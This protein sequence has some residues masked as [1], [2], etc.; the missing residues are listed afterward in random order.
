M[1]TNDWCTTKTAKRNLTRPPG[2]M[3]YCGKK[4][5]DIFLLGNQW[6]E[7]KIRVVGNLS[8]YTLDPG[9]MS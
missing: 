2:G 5:F 3:A 8:D 9:V 7:V 6:L 4:D 1:V